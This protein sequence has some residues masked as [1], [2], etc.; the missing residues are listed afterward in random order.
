MN[1]PS[2]VQR[3]V[4]RMKA[5]RDKLALMMGVATFEYEQRKAQIMASI[6]RSVAEEQ[7]LVGAHVQATKA[8]G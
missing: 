1:L 2:D 5:D 8:R 7:A 3:Q 4:D 6:A